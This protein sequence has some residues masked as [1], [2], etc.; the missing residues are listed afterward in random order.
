M[1]FLCETISFT[2]HLVSWTL[3]EK[4]WKHGV[5]SIEALG[6][7]RWALLSTLVY[8][9]YIVKMSVLLSGIAFCVRSFGV[10]KPLIVLDRKLAVIS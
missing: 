2:H 4:E 5:A 6:P 1:I 9:I 8:T 7:H 3:L 10:C